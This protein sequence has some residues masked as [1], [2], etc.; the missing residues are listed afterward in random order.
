MRENDI[1]PGIYYSLKINFYLNVKHFE[2]QN[3]TLLPGQQNVTH[4]EFEEVA[5]AQ[6]KEL[7][8]SYGNLTE[9]WFDG[10]TSDMADRVKDLLDEYQQD[11]ACYNGQGVTQNV[12]RWVGKDT[13]MFNTSIWSN[14][15][16]TGTGD[17]NGTE[18]CAVGCDT[19]LQDS[20]WFFQ[21]DDELKNMST[22]IEI[23]HDTVGNNGVLELDFGIDTTGNVHPNQAER[24][25]QFGDW[26]RNCYDNPLNSTKGVV[27][28]G[29]DAVLELMVSKEFDRV[30]IQENLLQGQRVRS[31]SVMVDN[32]KVYEGQGVGHKK[33]VLLEKSYNNANTKVELQ[34][35]EFVGD[36]VDIINFSVYKPCSSQ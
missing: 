17:P 7:W 4:Q 13:G 30:M 28:G 15:C 19:T 22:L 33:I 10:G 2:I 6:C 18:F 8:S 23:Y 36:N 14:G 11:A 32:V 25:K 20:G 1:G 29:K 16:K 26:I 3:T 9:I 12:V 5:L 21:S 24:Y 31:Y 34:L 27:G 35:T